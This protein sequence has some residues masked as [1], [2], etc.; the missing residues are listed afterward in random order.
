V[1]SDAGPV[2]AKGLFALFSVL[3]FYILVGYPLLLALAAR[4]RARPVRRGAYE[5]S[6]SIIIA[7]H[8][9]AQWLEA[10]LHS[11]LALDYPREKMEVVVVSDGSTD[12]S[13]AI[14]RQ[15]E[16]QGVRLV[17]VPKGGKPLALNAAIATVSGEILLLTDVRQMLA[18]NSVGCLM[19]CL[20]DPEV[21][22]VSG[23]LVIA[24][25][26]SQEE[27]Q[28]GLYWKFEVWLRDQLSLIDSM[29]GATGAFYAMRRELAVT[30]PADI[31]L[32]DVYLPLA[33]FFRGY[34]LIIEK[35]AY[36]YDV[37][38]RR[39]AE[40]RRKVRTLAGNYQILM[41]Y[42]SLL[43]WGNRMWWHFVSYKLGRLLLPWALIGMAL[44]SV[45][46]PDP[47]RWWIAG[48][49][50][51]GYALAGLDEWIPT[52]FPIKKLSSP[53]RTFVVMMAAAAMAVSVFFVPAQSLWKST[54][55]ETPPP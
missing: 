19:R 26:E 9:G 33:A 27:T 37:P 12:H 53:A 2:V 36:A 8:N 5:P 45:F 7:V 25:G 22:V 24:T 34:R 39:E 17:K 51:F 1:G 16:G 31:L 54:R 47:W 13:E 46:L 35:S 4:L 29:F 41:A 10:K 28:I 55:S 40:F 42:P 48:G 18:A 20:A 43:G 11:V 44:S 30:I 49:Q 50:A 38:T 32:D 52:G 6:I 21:G 15:F 23:E 3:V 14:A